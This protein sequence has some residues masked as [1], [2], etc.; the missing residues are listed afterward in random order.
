[1]PRSDEH[2]AGL[3]LL[4]LRQVVVAPRALPADALF[5]PPLVDDPIHVVAELAQFL[6]HEDIGYAEVALLAVRLDLFC[7]QHQ[8]PSVDRHHELVEFSRSVAAILGERLL[9]GGRDGQVVA[10]TL[11]Q[12]GPSAANEWIPSGLG[13]SEPL[14]ARQSAYRFLV[15][16]RSCK[17]LSAM[18]G[19]VSH[20]RS[21]PCPTLCGGRTAAC[22]ASPAWRYTAEGR[23]SFRCQYRSTAP[24]DCCF[25][26]SI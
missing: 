1:M 24:G 3:L 15:K 18:C 2:G 13:L 17:S 7:R 4:A 25:P 8:A 14:L 26:T 16:L 20:S 23:Q 19:P 11:R 9:R 10:R 21:S 6:V 12:N 22:S 5:A